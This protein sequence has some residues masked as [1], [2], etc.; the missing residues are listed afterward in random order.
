MPETKAKFPLQSGAVTS[1]ARN[2]SDNE[3]NVCSI[4]KNIQ[5]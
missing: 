2:S 4:H 3:R 1:F 5:L